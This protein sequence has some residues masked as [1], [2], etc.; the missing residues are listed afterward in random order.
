[1]KV[2]RSTLMVF[3][4]L[5]LLFTLIFGAS[6]AAEETL[7]TQFQSAAPQETQQ[8]PQPQESS[9]PRQGWDRLGV[10]SAS[11]RARLTLAGGQTGHGVI[12]GIQSCAILDCGNEQVAIF[13]PT[14]GG[15]IGLGASLLYTADDGITPGEAAAINA[16][17]IW[18]GWLGLM[19]GLVG[20]FD[21]D[22]VVRTMMAGQLV[23]T[24]GGYLLAQSLR[25]TAGD[26]RL[27]NSAGAWTVFYYLAITDG[28]LELNQSS[29]AL[30][31]G[32]LVSSLFGGLVG[33]QFSAIHPMSDSRVGI[34]SLS[35]GVGLLL[36][37]AIPVISAGTDI[38]GRTVVSMA[39]L[40]ATFGLVAGFLLTQDWDDPT[41]YGSTSTSLSVVPT[42]DGRG[43]V[44][45]V[46]GSF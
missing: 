35:G 42:L 44:G 34:I 24:A 3:L 41:Y 20:D 39:T 32:A 16:G 45:G 22:N 28:I 27:I 1:M 31:R 14:L 6:A 37:S 46:Q 11:P 12:L 23:G 8:A 36:G 7:S 25:P 2:S 33:A 13:M 29:T 4:V 10:E 38:S 26:V 18:G 9:P 21:S 30:Q 43:M 40:G 15:L 19:S 5:A 17:T